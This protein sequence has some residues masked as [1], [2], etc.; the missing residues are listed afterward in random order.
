MLSPLLNALGRLL[1]KII[2]GRIGQW[3]S[4]LIITTLGLY[5]TYVRWMA[6]QLQFHKRPIRT[7]GQCS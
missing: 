3:L 2:P 5:L 1:E 6:R 7:I 4:L